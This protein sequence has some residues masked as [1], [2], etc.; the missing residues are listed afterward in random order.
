MDMAHRSRQNKLVCLKTDTFYHFK[1]AKA[2]PIELFRRSRGENIGG[3]Q[4][5]QI[6]GF[7]FD[8][9]V[10]GVVIFRLKILRVFDVLNEAFMNFME[11][12]REFFG[13]GSGVR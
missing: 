7:E 9:F 5:N 12:G 4:P 8:G 6:A 2:L 1:G 13:S 3:I 11:I 10:L